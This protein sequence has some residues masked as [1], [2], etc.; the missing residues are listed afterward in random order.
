VPADNTFLRHQ[1]AFPAQTATAK[2]VNI[3]HNK[4]LLCV[5]HV[6]AT[7]IF[8]M[9]FVLQIQAPLLLQVPVQRNAPLATSSIAQ[10]PAHPAERAVSLAQQR[11]TALHAPIA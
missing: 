1:L 5:V 4:I 3:L 9:V 6:L 8:R 11:T 2:F 10:I 7:T